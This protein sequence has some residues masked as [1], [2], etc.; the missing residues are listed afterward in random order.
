MHVKVF[1]ATLEG[2][3]AFPVEVEVHLDGGL[4]TFKLS[5]LGDAAIKEAEVRVQCA[6]STAGFHN[7][8]GRLT[9]NLA[10]AVNKKGGT[11]F[12]LPIA[13][14]TLLVQKMLPASCLD[15][16][17][18]VGELALSGEVRPVRG[19]LAAVESAKRKGCTKAFVPAE[20]AAE[21][22]LV[23][24]VDVFGVDALIDVV[25]HLKQRKGKQL[26]AAA[27]MPPVIDENGL[28]LIDVKGQLTARRALEI[29]AA[30]GHN[31]LFVGGPGAGKS[32]LARRLPGILPPLTHEEA[33][34][35]TRV[36]S[37]AGLNVGQGLVQR[38]PFRA[39]HHTTTKPGMSGG[40]SGIPGPGEMTLA[41]HGVLF[42]DELPEFEKRVLEVMREPLETGLLHLRRSKAAVTYPCRVQLVAAMNPCPC[43]N[44]GDAKRRCRCSAY[45]VNRYQ[46]KLSAP[47]LDRI[48]LHVHVPPVD[49]LSLHDQREGE[50]SSSVKARV[51]AARTRQQQRQ[52]GKINALMGLRDL[53]EHVALCDAGKRVLSRAIDVL[54]LSARGY[55]RIRRVA[56]TIADLDGCDDVKSS[57][58]AEALQFR[59]LTSRMTATARPIARAA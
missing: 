40:G 11:G 15:D 22:A 16:A 33:L 49:V 7:P 23:D 14:G 20:N 13:L 37:L 29:A 44:L 50:P 51:V 43:G 9:V 1:S 55:D 19:V 31:L 47:L 45:D 4:P 28:D 52:G 39:P 41:H 48:D 56:R 10:P 32:M 59:S 18:A 2:V 25:H 42:L 12:D 54:G 24:G 6:L 30:G 5:G 34:E 36:H 38:R 53:D 35:V 3:D 57:H 21:A 46:G 58:V 27:P 17:I 26:V 8:P